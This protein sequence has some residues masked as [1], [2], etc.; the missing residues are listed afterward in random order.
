MNDRLDSEDNAALAANILVPTEGTRVAFLERS[1]PATGEGDKSLADLVPT[2]VRLALGQLLVAF[3]VFA[4]WRARRL[5]KP[6][7]EVPPV[8]DRGLRARRC[9]RQSA[10]EVG[11]APKPA[12]ERLRADLHRELV[13]RLGVSPSATLTSSRTSRRSAPVSIG[14]RSRQPLAGPAPTTPEALVAVAR[15]VEEVRTASSDPRA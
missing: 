15:E 4:L 3:V 6:V 11:Q 9:R 5:G 2:G 8:R 7:A 13:G 14:T 12:A 10:A 1:N